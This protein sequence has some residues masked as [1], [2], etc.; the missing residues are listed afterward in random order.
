MYIFVLYTVVS[1]THIRCV[2]MVIMYQKTYGK[3]QKVRSNKHGKYIE[4]QH[5]RYH[6]YMKRKCYQI[7]NTNYGL[8]SAMGNM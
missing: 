7:P 6:L 5:D 8:I 1:M 4:F 3:G 2:E